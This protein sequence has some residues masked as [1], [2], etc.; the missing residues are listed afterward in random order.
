MN[1]YSRDLLISARLTCQP[2]NL[3]NFPSSVEI[4][5]AWENGGSGVGN[6][7]NALRSAIGEFYERQHFY[8]DVIPDL[9]GGLDHSLKEIEISKFIQA[10]TQTQQQH[11]TQ[12]SLNLHQYNLSHVL[13]MSDLSSC[14]IPT[15]CITLS[16]TRTE[17]ENSIYPLRDT[18]GCAFGWHPEQA[19]LG[20]IK[21][22]LERQ[23]LTRF[24]LTNTC[25]KIIDSPTTSSTLAGTCVETLC[26][27]LM[28]SGELSFIDISDI[29]YPGVCILVV[30]GQQNPEHNVRYCAGMAYA[31][32]L[33]LAMEK[34][35]LELWQTYRF[36][37]L[38]VATEQKIGDIHD[39]Y[40]KYF[41]QCNSYETY[42]NI[43]SIRTPTLVPSR[44]TLEPLCL[45]SLLKG[46]TRH[47]ALGYIYL[48][49]ISTGDHFG[50][51]SKFI[52]PDFFMH[53]NNSRNINLSNLYSQ[54]FLFEI[55][56]DR[57]E[58]MVPFP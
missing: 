36:I 29:E 27:A 24:W 19:I 14:Y 31:A 4:T 16:T 44:S 35:L 15:A 56:P 21:E 47:K 1:I 43:T 26:K 23:F 45:L 58:Q 32:T 51:C 53:M 18:C 40:L 54:P 48:K 34:S 11:L 13:R 52:S 3:L 12:P 17:T 55:Q 2:A 6:G 20:S 39:S 30:Y 33:E 42:K 28:I 46:L 7:S 50:Y 25:I 37:D 41:L 57:K 9:V 38:F 49:M 5:D 8:V 22:F 10:F